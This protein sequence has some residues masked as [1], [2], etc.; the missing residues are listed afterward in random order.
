M[1]YAT[2]VEVA[3]PV[4][5]VWRVLEDVEAW[6]RWTPSMT[7]VSRTATGPLTVGETVRVRQPRLPEATWTVT[8]VYPGSAF[9]WVS[10]SPGVV[11]T[12]TH[13]VAPLPT[14]SRVTLG[15]EQHGPL[16]GVVGMLL[17]RTVRRYVDQE[18]AGLKARV[19]SD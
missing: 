2:A 7:S 8:A 1:R 12:G 4:G 10:R 9:T 11:T 14:G 16:A 5:V 15:L 13:V 6:P 3:A 19:E 18:A 17:G